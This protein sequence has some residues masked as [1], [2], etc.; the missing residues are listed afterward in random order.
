MDLPDIDEF[1]RL[2]QIG[3]FKAQDIGT[4]FG[5]NNDNSVND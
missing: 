4:A 2:Q 5:W 3:A 1:K